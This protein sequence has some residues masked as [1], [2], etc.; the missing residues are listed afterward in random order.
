MYADSHK[1]DMAAPSE[2]TSGKWI[3]EAAGNIFHTV[4]DE[5]L[6]KNEVIRKFIREEDRRFVV[7]GKGMGKTL[8]LAYKRKILEDKYGS[9]ALFIPTNTPYIGSMIKL[10]DLTSDIIHYLEDFD[11]CKSIWLL[12]IELSALSQEKASHV[13][14]IEAPGINPRSPKKFKWFIEE[15]LKYPLGFDYVLD[16]ILAFTSKEIRQFISEF[17]MIVDNQFRCLDRNIMY[18]FDR[19]DQALNH[20]DDK[21]WIPI[22]T[23][24]LEAAWEAKRSNNHVKIYLSIRQEAYAEL[25]TYNRGSMQSEVSVIKYRNEELQ[26]L[27]NQLLLYYEGKHT[28]KE[29]LGVTYLHNNTTNKRE[30]V[31]SF[32]NRYSLGR[33]RDFVIF[34]GNMTDCLQEDGTAKNNDLG[35]RLKKAIIETSSESIIKSLHSELRMLMKCV[36]TMERFDSFVELLNYNILTYEDMKRI[37]LQFHTTTGDYDCN[38]DCKDCRKD[39]HPFCDLYNMGLLGI[40]DTN[41]DETETLIQ[42][43]KPP[44]GRKTDG[45]RGNSPFFLIHP[46][47]RHYIDDLHQGTSVGDKYELLP[48]ILVGD[49]LDWRPID[50]KVAHLDML[51]LKISHSKIRKHLGDYIRKFAKNKG[52]LD[53]PSNVYDK[54]RELIDDCATLTDEDSRHILAMCGKLKCNRDQLASL[55]SACNDKKHVL[56][57]MNLETAKEPHPAIPKPPSAPRRLASSTLDAKDSVVK[58]YHR[59]NLLGTGFL[60][61]FKGQGYVVTCGHIL[62]CY[63][64]EIAADKRVV[65]QLQGTNVQRV[66]A[67][68]VSYDNCADE[69]RSAKQDVA[70]LKISANSCDSLPYLTGGADS[71]F[72]PPMTAMTYGFPYDAQLGVSI[73]SFYDWDDLAR[74]FKEV[75]SEDAEKAKAGVSGSPIIDTSKSYS[76]VGMIKGRQAEKLIVIPFPLIHEVLAAHQVKG[77]T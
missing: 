28:F 1:G 76:L 44:Y 25:L 53:F 3:T 66:A 42:R 54:L 77:G 39:A 72:A 45:L 6:Y 59:D 29:F 74:G 50:T 68:V 63:G 7:A 65:V 2:I 9:N 26:S 8:L 34:C 15:M 18:F 19:V 48:G 47:L 43:F 67:D 58:I 35:N 60:Y 38:D 4:K 40:I 24:L 56:D 75:K 16:R 71:V 62:D 22:Q 31:Y 55:Q 52:K 33:P 5:F 14:I 30:Q 27:I 70:I 32:M 61:C 23:G 11:H 37:C 69:D 57:A 51:L 64:D 49:G 46:A 10:R 12:A 13:P 21:I 73:T 36:N 20:S 41:H 17:G